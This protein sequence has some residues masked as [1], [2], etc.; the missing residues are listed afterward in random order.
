MLS[1]ITGVFMRSQGGPLLVLVTW[2]VRPKKLIF[3]CSRLPLLLLRFKTNTSTGRTCVSFLF[4]QEGSFS[5]GEKERERKRERERHHE[6]VFVRMCEKRECIGAMRELKKQNTNGKGLVQG[7]T[8]SQARKQEWAKER[9]IQELVGEE[10]GWE[11]SLKILTKRETGPDLDPW[12][13]LTSTHIHVTYE[14]DLWRSSALVL[15]RWAQNS[16]IRRCSLQQRKIKGGHRFAWRYGERESERESEKE[17]R[18]TC[19]HVGAGAGAGEECWVSPWSKG[20][21]WKGSPWTACMLLP[22]M[23]SQKRSLGPWSMVCVCVWR[24]RS[25]YPCNAMHNGCVQIRRQDEVR[26]RAQEREG[27]ENAAW[28]PATLASM[29]PC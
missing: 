15:L 24:T 10:R 13:L 26:G 25:T 19:R 21:T 9:K 4:L 14:H 18:H 27:C 6:C 16:V 1:W 2:L 8:A 7:A 20:R 12:D 17:S 3:F 11:T 29:H 23:W 5:R 28:Q 22:R